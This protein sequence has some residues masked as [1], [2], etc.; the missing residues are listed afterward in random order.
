MLYKE[1]IMI[2]DRNRYTYER[3]VPVSQDLQNL[4]RERNRIQAEIHLP[5]REEKIDSEKTT[6]KDKRAKKFE[7]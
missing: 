4:L 1:R 5:L 6:T 7:Q 3:G 2:L